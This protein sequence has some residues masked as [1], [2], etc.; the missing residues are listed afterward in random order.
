MKNLSCANITD[1]TQWEGTMLV[2][3]RMSSPKNQKLVKGEWVYLYDMA[4]VTTHALIATVQ[5]IC[6]IKI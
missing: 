4:D 5:M 6:D 3:D 2:L 1:S